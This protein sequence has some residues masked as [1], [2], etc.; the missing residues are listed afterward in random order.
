VTRSGAEIKP[1]PPSGAGGWHAVVVKFPAFGVLLAR[2]LDHRR[3]DIGS[4]SQA[5]GVPEP[6]AAPGVVCS[7]EGARVLLQWPHVRVRVHDRADRQGF[8]AMRSQGTFRETG[9][10]G[11]SGYGLPDQ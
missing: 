3:M 11:G 7:G 4:L 5:A 1:I 9:R 6:E 10:R 2:L 8:Y